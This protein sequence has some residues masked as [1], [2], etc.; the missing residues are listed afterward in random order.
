MND[1]E[2]IDAIQ[3][4][5]SALRSLGMGD[6]MSGKGAVEGLTVALVGGDPFKETTTSVAGAL[7][8]VARGLHDIADAI[9][10][11]RE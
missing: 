1:D 3:S 11:R 5:A 8:A 10:E 6:G 7:L 9:R 2:T 4:I